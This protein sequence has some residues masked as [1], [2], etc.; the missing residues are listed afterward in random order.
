MLTFPPVF[1]DEPDRPGRPGNCSHDPDEGNCPGNHAKSR[2]VEGFRGRQYQQAPSKANAAWAIRTQ[3][4]ARFPAGALALQ[5][6][7]ESGTGCVRGRSLP[8]GEFR[9]L[10]IKA[11]NFE[12]HISVC[13]TRRFR[14][15]NQLP[16]A[17][18]AEPGRS[19]GTLLAR[20]PAAP[21]AAGQSDCAAVHGFS[22]GCSLWPM[23]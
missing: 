9:I 22:C 21:G 4:S 2:M 17:D 7:P 19:A 13:L 6:S 12:I 23:S 1:S 11:P 3:A 15:P 14:L 8:P 20:L 18:S 16:G 5:V 10:S